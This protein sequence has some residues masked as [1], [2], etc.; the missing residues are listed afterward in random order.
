[1]AK[2]RVGI[3][4]GSGYT[5]GEVLRLLLGHPEAE[6]V[7]ITSDSYAG[8]PVTW[9][10]PNL[11]KRTQLRFSAH[12]ELTE[13]DT[14]F[15]CLPHGES[16]KQMARFESLAER[17]IDLSADFRLKCQLTYRQY[18]G[19]DHLLPDRL[20]RFVYGIPELH[21]EEMRQSRYVSSAGCNATAVIL[22]LWPVFK[23]GLA[24]VNRTVADVKTGSSEGGVSVSAGSHHPERSGAVRS[25]SP[26]G[27]RHGAE[28][29]QE[30]SCNGPVT[31][32]MSATSVELVR[33]VLATCHVFLKQKL[34]LKDIWSVY[35]KE[36]GNE[37]FIRFVAENHGVFRFP[38][39]KLLAGTNFCDVGFELDASGE[40]LVVISAIDNL[41]KGAAG[42]AIQAFNLMHGFAETTALEFTGLHPL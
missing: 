24:E 22:A 34:A 3:V 1:M 5:G 32:H 37:P 41:M 30:L 29:M 7:Q 14:L 26:T 38:E 39:P 33:G 12:R 25:Y 21:R 40:R 35:R 9:A 8:K 20:S 15:L 4:G 2:V 28:I 10:H 18:Y 16:M 13:C 19:A 23:N 11:R 36:Y 6:I 31:I 42:Q 17:I 27:H